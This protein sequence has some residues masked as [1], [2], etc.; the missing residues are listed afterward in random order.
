MSLQDDKNDDIIPFLDILRKTGDIL[1]AAD[2]NGHLAALSAPFEWTLG[3]PAA[4]L[5]GKS[6]V[7]LVHP[8]DN[9]D[10]QALLKD[11]RLRQTGK[12]RLRLRTASGTYRLFELST[13][14][15][16]NEGTIA[17]IV[18]TAHDITE[19][20]YDH[21]TKVQAAREQER[22]R[23]LARLVQDLSHDIRTPLSVIST[24]AYLARR[25]IGSHRSSEAMAHLLNIENQVTLLGER[26]A[27]ILTV[28][29][30]EGGLTQYEFIEH[31]VNLIAGAVVIDLQPQAIDAQNTLRFVSSPDPLNV[32]VDEGAL[33]RALWHLV[34]NAINYTPAGGSIEVRTE[35]QKREIMIAVEDTGIGMT[36]DEVSQIFDLFYRADKARNHETGGVGLGLPI[37]QHLVRAHGGRIEVSSEPGVGSKFCIF[38]PRQR[39]TD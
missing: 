33:R 27:N 10:I 2:T 20:H 35:D 26:L 19:A 37:A 11:L 21:I 1:F 9:A 32:P 14:P 31:D 5:V 7:E 38:I 8:D 16:M 4:E 6:I 3:W 17:G 18:G 23:L 12:Y 29:H 39:N 30:L 25:K 22:V 13:Y 15:A 34:V 36:A 28:R 24:N